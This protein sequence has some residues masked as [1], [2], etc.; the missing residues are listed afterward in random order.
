MSKMRFWCRDGTVTKETKDAGN[1]Q[2][3]LPRHLFLSMIFKANS[4][5]VDLR[6]E[7]IPHKH[8]S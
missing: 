7:Q 2:L 6:T 3:T 1:L 8:H 5:P 4:F